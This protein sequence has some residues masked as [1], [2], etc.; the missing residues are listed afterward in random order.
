MS[1][2]FD[3]K[4]HPS[5]TILLDNDDN[6][7]KRKRSYSDEP[8]C[9]EKTYRSYNKTFPQ[10]LYEILM[11]PELNHILSFLPN[12]GMWKVHDKR[13]FESE[14]MKKYFKTNKWESFLRQVTGWGFKRS[15][16]LIHIVEIWKERQYGTH[17]F[18]DSFFYTFIYKHTFVFGLFRS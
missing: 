6:Q 4:L 5:T 2:S 3:H 14:V 10:I 15:K 13:Q 7:A 12:G 16:L 1:D 8:S 18:V 17:S 9:Q 11:K